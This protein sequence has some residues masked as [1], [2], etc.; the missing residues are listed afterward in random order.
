MLILA[1]VSGSS[2]LPSLASYVRRCLGADA[3]YM[4]ACEALMPGTNALTTTVPGVL[5]R[6]ASNW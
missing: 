1:K 6:K 3:K 4:E 5:S 2:D